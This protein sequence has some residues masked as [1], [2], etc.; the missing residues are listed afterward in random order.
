MHQRSEETKFS[1]AVHDLLL[2]L[3]TFGIG[4][5]LLPDPHSK[6]GADIVDAMKDGANGFAREHGWTER[7]TQMLMNYLSDHLYEK[8]PHGFTHVPI[9]KVLITRA[10]PDDDSEP[11]RR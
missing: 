7:G 6:E 9:N 10:E 11:N 3:N 8:G 5:V 4:L 2:N 1:I